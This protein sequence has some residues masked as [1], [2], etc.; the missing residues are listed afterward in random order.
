MLQRAAARECERALSVEFS[1]ALA[2]CV[3][4]PKARFRKATDALRRSVAVASIL[5][6]RS[7]T[8]GNTA[9]ATA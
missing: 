8:A 6:R 9:A 7:E 3:D 2:S 4:A 5:S 1:R